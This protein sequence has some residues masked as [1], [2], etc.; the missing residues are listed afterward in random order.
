MLQNEDIHKIDELKTDFT[1]SWFEVENILKLIDLFNFSSLLNSFS[2]LKKQG[3]GFQYVI[4]A[5]LLLPF[6]GACNVNTVSH[7]QI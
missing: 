5:L 7:N 6:L 2:I 1:H 4:A 3:F